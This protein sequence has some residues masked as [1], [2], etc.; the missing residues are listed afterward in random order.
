MILKLKENTTKAISARACTKAA[1]NF[2]QYINEQKRLMMPD[3]SKPYDPLWN[4]DTEQDASESVNYFLNMMAAVDK[5]TQPTSALTV[6]SRN[7]KVVGILQRWVTKQFRLVTEEHISCEQKREFHVVRKEHHYLLTLHLHQE[8]S[9]T[10]L[11]LQDLIDDYFTA[12]KIKGVR[13]E[14]CKLKHAAPKQTVI[15][16]IGSFV[17]LSLK[18]FLWNAEKKQTEKIKTA[19]DFTTPVVVRS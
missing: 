15:A 13:C 2:I 14:H 17:L 4:V 16:E 10:S 19:V 6:T 12:K 3:L 1:V 11:S 5:P 7:A 18:R 9:K 8:T